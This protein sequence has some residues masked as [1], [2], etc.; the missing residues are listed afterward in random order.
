M[1]YTIETHEDD[2]E[3]VG[4]VRQGDDNGCQSDGEKFI[5]QRVNHKVNQICDRLRRLA[6]L[7]QA[8][9]QMCQFTR[10]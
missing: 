5:D 7:A 6:Q 1:D 10:P 3:G 9:H 8:F 4:D 2:D